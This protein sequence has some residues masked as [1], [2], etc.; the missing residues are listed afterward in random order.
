MK[1]NEID[2]QPGGNPVNQVA[3]GSAQKQDCAQPGLWPFPSD[4]LPQQENG[5]QGRH[6]YDHKKQPF[7]FQQPEGSAGIQHI[8]TAYQ[9]RD[10]RETH[11]RGHGLGNEKF[12]DPVQQDHTN[13]QR[14]HRD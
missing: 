14:Q 6:R 7:V 5:H 4:M 12:G 13:K 8:S 3:Q 10:D 11:A 9:A 1:I 2:Y